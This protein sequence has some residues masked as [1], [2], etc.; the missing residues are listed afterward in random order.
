M[1][2]RDI[3]AALGYLALGTR[4]KRL[5]EQLQAGVAQVLA[6][7][8]S[9][10]QPGQLP[11]LVAID[12]GAGLTVAQLVEALGAT[13]PAVS[14]SLGALQRSGLIELVGDAGDARIRRPVLTA[15]AG[16]QLDRIRAELFPRVDAAAEELCEG[17]NLLEMIAAVEARNRD[18]PFAE[19]IRTVAA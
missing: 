9:P 12:Q 14:R 5:A 17:L 10:L 11:L 16:R 19:R 2:Y 7:M 6:E 13:Q 3:V 1:E 15:S 4:L 8:G 18:L